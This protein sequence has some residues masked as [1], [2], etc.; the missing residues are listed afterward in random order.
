MTKAS[1]LVRQHSVP[2]RIVDKSPV[3]S[4]WVVTQHFSVEKRCV[5]THITTASERNYSTILTR[6]EGF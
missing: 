5:T 3:A 4:N 2:S 1:E 6:L